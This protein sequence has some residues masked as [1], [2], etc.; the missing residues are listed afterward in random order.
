MVAINSVSWY[1]AHVVTTTFLLL[2]VYI[3]IKEKSAFLAGLFLAGAF[4]TRISTSLGVFFFLGYR[5]F[6]KEKP[7]KKRFLQLLYFSIPIIGG[8]LLFFAYNYARFENIM[9]TGYT[10][11]LLYP[12]LVGNRTIGT[13]NLKHFPTNLYL[14]FIKTPEFVFK[15]GT[16]ITSSIKPTY[17]GMSFLYTSP[18]FL[19]L[20][21]INLKERINLISLT[22]ASFIS[23]FL[24]GSF[25]LGAYQYG[26]RFALD[27]QPFL[28]LALTKIFEIITGY[29]RFGSIRGFNFL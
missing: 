23:L 12:E 15:E 18:I 4:L 29:T 6:T 19:H 13:W 22:T 24:F 16:F 14:F 7:A 11:Q 25:G 10:F 28:F 2:Y 21:R 27:F 3:T 26:Y 8:I 5:L 17:I 1:F 9:E 20:I